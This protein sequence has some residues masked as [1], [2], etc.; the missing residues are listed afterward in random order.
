L[1]RFRLRQARR[2]LESG[3][4]SIGEVAAA[5]GYSDSSYFCRVFR[6]ETGMSP[7]DYIRAHR[8]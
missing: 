7:S 3:T 4:L 6:R 2:L 1:N 5:V 8:P